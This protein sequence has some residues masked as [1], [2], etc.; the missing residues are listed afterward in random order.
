MDINAKTFPGLYEACKVLD[1]RGAGYKRVL[2]VRDDT[3]TATNGVVII[4]CRVQLPDGL[5]RPER[6]TKSEISLYRQD[7]NAVSYPD[8]GR[9][10]DAEGASLDVDGVPLGVIMLRL[11][12]ESGAAVDPELL[13]YVYGPRSKIVGARVALLNGP[14]VFDLENGMTVAVMQLS[15]SAR[16]GG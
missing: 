12:V 3:A 8:V 15:E 2:S 5:Y 11:A 13:K 4:R 9:I 6:V 16:H 14:V 1:R 10:L 7:D